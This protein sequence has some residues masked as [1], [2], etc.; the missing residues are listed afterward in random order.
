MTQRG[1]LCYNCVSKP[2]SLA[3]LRYRREVAMLDPTPLIQ[4]RLTHNRWG[5]LGGQGC[6]L[7]FDVGSYGLR[8]A[9]V[10]L[11][12]HTF[13][14][15]H[16]EPANESPQE[17]VGGAIDLGNELMA[18]HGVTCCTPGSG[19]RRFRRTGGCAAGYRSALP[20][21]AGLG[22]LPAA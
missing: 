11:S 21:C 12:R 8:A 10:D 5:L 16:R 1:S 22:T 18:A 14:A 3:L 13:Y 4:E 6:V 9:L 7:G 17:L 15:M 2:H 19:W 20:A